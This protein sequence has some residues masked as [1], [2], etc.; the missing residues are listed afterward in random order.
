MRESRNRS[1]TFAATARVLKQFGYCAGGVSLYSP[2][3]AIS[4]MDESIASLSTR[5]QQKDSS[6]IA[7]E[8]YSCDW[9]SERIKRAPGHCSRSPPKTRP[10][11]EDERFI[12]RDKWR[13]IITI[14]LPVIPS[15][16]A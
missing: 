8:N 5:C 2:G 16:G 6:E 15:F 13:Y 14:D 10:A 1:E 9:S 3:A 4:L 12:S 11:D 7:V